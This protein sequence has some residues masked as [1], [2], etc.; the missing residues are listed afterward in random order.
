MHASETFTPPRSVVPS[1]IGFWG[2]WRFLSSVGVLLCTLACAGSLTAQEA[3]TAQAVKDELAKLPYRVLF[4]S[5]SDQNWDLWSIRPDGSERTNLTKTAQVHELYP[6]AS[7]DGSQIAFLVDQQQGSETQRSL[8]VMNADGT[9]RRQVS[10]AAREPTWSPDGKQIAFPKQEFTRFQVKDFVSKR[11]YFFHLD[12]SSTHVHPNESIEHLYVLTWLAGGDW[13]VSTVHGG[14]GLGHGIVAIEV[15][16]SRVV[17]LKIPGCRPASSEDGKHLCWSSDDHTI[18]VGDIEMSE[19]GPRIVNAR[20]LHH[21]EKMH[22]YHPDFSPDGR[23][24]TFSVGPGGRVAA[25]GPGTQTEVAEMIGV[26][27]PW[28]LWVKAIDGNSPA[29]QITHDAKLSNK[30][31]EWTKAP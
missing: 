28:D 16:G 11:L 27:G 31:S 21:D 18:H 26:A 2:A 14:M 5:Y 4:E 22:L 30:E 8:W 3:P 17:D 9:N 25:S 20:A 12:D 13:I 6:Q 23:F 19:D 1:W 15:N 29:I 7:A 10:T 24:V